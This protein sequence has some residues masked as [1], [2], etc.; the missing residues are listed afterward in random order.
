MV[1]RA[2]LW[3]TSTVSTAFPSRAVTWISSDFAREMSLHGAT[4]TVFPNRWIAL[5]TVR[6]ADIWETPRAFTASR[7][8]HSPLKGSENPVLVC[9]VVV[10]AEMDYLHNVVSIRDTVKTPT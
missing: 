1:N 9:G 10:I 8:A 7:N 6:L 2:V 3:T 4:A 5:R